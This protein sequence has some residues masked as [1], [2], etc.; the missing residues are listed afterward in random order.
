MENRQII[1]RRYIKTWFFLDLFTSL[2]YDDIVDTTS[3][4]NLV[5]MVPIFRLLKLLKL[6]RAIKLKQMLNNILLSL[7][8]G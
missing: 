8:F 2:P 7:E 5:R 4:V 6:L 1:I 3:N